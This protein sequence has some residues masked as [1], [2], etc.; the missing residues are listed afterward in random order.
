MSVSGRTSRVHLPWTQN[1]IIFVLDLDLGIQCGT[2]ARG[3]QSYNG[4]S[5]VWE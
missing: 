3:G 4:T 1:C 5:V 2:R